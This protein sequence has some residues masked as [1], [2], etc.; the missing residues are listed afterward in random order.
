MK[1]CPTGKPRMFAAAQ[2]GVSLFAHPVYQ[3]GMPR[4]LACLSAQ[5]AQQENL[6]AQVHL[7]AQFAQQGNL[8]VRVHRIA[9]IAHRGKYGNRPGLSECVKCPAGKHGI[10][11]VSANSSSVCTICPAGKFAGAGALYCSDCSAGRYGNRP[12]L[13]ECVKC[14]AGKHSTKRG[15]ANSS[16]CLRCKDEGKYSP[17]AGAQQCERCPVG[18]EPRVTGIK[19]FIPDRLQL[20]MNTWVIFFPLDVVMVALVVVARLWCESAGHRR[21]NFLARLGRV[22]CG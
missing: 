17:E 22:K 2:Y 4:T 7:Y 5:F 10:N 3:E 20:L 19:C 12:G 14:P 16:L 15:S 9:Q 21:E 13:S 6:R 18:Q 11:R 8:Q 1:N